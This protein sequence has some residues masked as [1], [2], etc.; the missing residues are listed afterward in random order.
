MNKKIIIILV[1]FVFIE[2]IWAGF[3]LRAKT[4]LQPGLSKKETQKADTETSLSFSPQNQT[5]TLNKPFKVKIM[6]NT[7]KQNASAVDTVISYDPK[8]LKTAEENITPGTIFPSYP[9]IKNDPQKGEIDITATTIDPKQ[10]PFQ[11]YD[12]FATIEF[13]PIKTGQTNLS[14]DFTK[15]KTNDSNIIE[16]KSIKDI[17]EKVN[18]ASY[19]IK[20]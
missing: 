20:N 9:L 7:N 5:L 11:G 15:G 19:T 18:N 10:T 8:F 3:Y 6:V 13:T 4:P 1:I 12:V 2:L 14:F 17:L 16:P